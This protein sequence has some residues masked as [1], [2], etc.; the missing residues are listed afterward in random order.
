MELANL[1][2]A[3]VYLLEK[4]STVLPGRAAGVEGLFD[5]DEDGNI[6]E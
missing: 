6:E 4:P 2:D 5:E 1:K 3:C